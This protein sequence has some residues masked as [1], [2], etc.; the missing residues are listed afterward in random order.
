[1]TAKTAPVGSALGAGTTQ[2]FVLLIVLFVTGS[3]YMLTDLFSPYT[4]PL[5]LQSGCQLAAGVNPNVNG[6]STSAGR[7]VMPSTCWCVGF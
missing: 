3:A 6:C 4:D 2:R 1:V 7:H 5:T